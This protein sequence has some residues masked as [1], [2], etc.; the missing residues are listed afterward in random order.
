MNPAGFQPTWAGVVF[1]GHP[2]V[3]LCD[4][5]A[6]VTAIVTVALL[7]TLVQQTNQLPSNR[8]SNGAVSEDWCPHWLATP[9]PAMG[10]RFDSETRRCCRDDSVAPVPSPIIVTA[11]QPRLDSSS[12][13]RRTQ[14]VNGKRLRTAGVGPTEVRI[15]AA[16]CLSVVQ[17]PRRLPVEEE[18]H[19]RVVPE[20]LGAVEEPGIRALTEFSPASRCDG[21]RSF[22]SPVMRPRRF[23]SCPPLWPM[24]LRARS[25]LQWSSGQ[26]HGPLTVE[27]PVQI[28]A[29]A[30]TYN[31]GSF[32]AS[33]GIG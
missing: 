10:S 31:I 7:E 9:V 17:R 3:H 28:R 32:I 27:P 14:A 1:P 6:V 24:T 33:C 5:S 11:W 8:Q 23:E 19:V 21:E 26:T 18:T 30:F 2:E 16:T 13:R 15:L 25:A 20:R 29:G 12:A 22:V 4:V